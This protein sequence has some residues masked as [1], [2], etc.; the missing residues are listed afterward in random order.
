MIR[1]CSKDP[2]FELTL[3]G[4][5]ESDSQFC[6]LVLVLPAC[7]KGVAGQDDFVQGLAT[8]CVHISIHASVL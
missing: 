1:L 2:L 4:K 3:P 5:P 6:S 7:Q 8:L